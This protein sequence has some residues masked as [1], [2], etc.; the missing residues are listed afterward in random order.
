MGELS[1]EQIELCRD[2][3]KSALTDYDIDALCDMALR[4]LSGREAVIDECAWTEDEDYWE[5]GCGEKW[6]FS[7]PETPKEHGMEFCYHCGKRLTIRAL[8][9]PTS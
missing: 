5:T 9:E 8:K 4:G 6:V 3:P 1:R 2:L 7:T